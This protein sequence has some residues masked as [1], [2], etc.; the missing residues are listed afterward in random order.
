VVERIA[1]KDGNQQL[2]GDSPALMGDMLKNDFPQI[3]NT[4]RLNAVGAVIKQDD[5]VH[6]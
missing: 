4:A 2:W 3:K 1:E 5:N 6:L